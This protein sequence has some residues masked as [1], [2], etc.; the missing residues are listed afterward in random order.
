MN[1]R[2]RKSWTASLVILMLLSL[3]FAA[4]CQT[5]PP[6]A[7]TP[8]DARGG[9]SLGEPVLHVPLP[10]PTTPPYSYMPFPYVPEPSPRIRLRVEVLSPEPGA[11]QTPLDSEAGVADE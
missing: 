7:P 5:T 6:P 9:G 11:Y 1:C 4:G 8:P 10:T 2:R 3:G